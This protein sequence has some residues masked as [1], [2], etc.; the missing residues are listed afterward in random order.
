MTGDRQALFVRSVK[1]LKARI[2]AGVSVV[3]R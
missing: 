3:V 2:R 1:V